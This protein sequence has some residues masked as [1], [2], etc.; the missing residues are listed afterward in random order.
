MKTNTIVTKKRKH[1]IKRNISEESSEVEE[2]ADFAAM[3]FEFDDNQFECTAYV[4]SQANVYLNFAP[5]DRL[6]EKVNLEDFG[7]G[8]TEIF[9]TFIAFDPKSSSHRQVLEYL[10]NHKKCNISLELDYETFIAATPE[11]AIQM[12]KDLYLKGLRA[13]L[14]FNIRDFDMEGLIAA[15]E[16]A[17]EEE[18][19]QTPEGDAMM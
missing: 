13:L 15:V 1:Q 9:F 17:L 18:D 19:E 10:P 12:M 16:Q 6:N 8:V 3:G 11:V 5:F 7:G 2:L 4:D 14:L